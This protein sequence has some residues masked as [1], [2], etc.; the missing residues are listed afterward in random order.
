MPSL[1]HFRSANK[2]D[3]NFIDVP[4]S[5]FI[6]QKEVGKNKMYSLLTKAGPI[7]TFSEK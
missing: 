4:N 7:I 5:L 1:H 3:T 2:H 6:L